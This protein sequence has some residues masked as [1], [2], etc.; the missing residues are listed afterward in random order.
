M[1]PSRRLVLSSSAVLLV[2][3]LVGC[4]GGGEEPPA[5]APTTAQQT[6]QAPEPEPTEAE[7]AAFG[8]TAENFAATLAQAQAALS[9]QSLTMEMVSTSPAGDVTASAAVSAAADGTPEMVMV[10]AIPGV[11]DVEMRMVGG[12]VYMNMGELT[13]GGFLAFDP[14]DPALGDVGMP[15]KVD[16]AADAAALE[17]AIVSVEKAGPVETMDGV[18]VQPYDVVIDL[19]KV[20]GTAREAMDTAAEELAAAGQSLPPSTAYHY[21]IGEDGLIRR[22]VYELAGLRTEMTFS[23]WGEPVVVEAPTPDQIVEM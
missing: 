22:T 20:S 8:L 23:D 1:S 13:G 19:T 6:S 12:V 9:R 10:M 16:P 2:V 14:N 4:S 3:G 11:G 5:E 18:R 7:P 21:W 17:G 15:T